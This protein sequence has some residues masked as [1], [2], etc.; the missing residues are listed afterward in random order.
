VQSNHPDPSE[1]GS[2]ANESGVSSED[3]HGYP[4]LEPHYNIA[5]TSLHPILTL[6]PV[7]YIADDL[8]LSPKKV[9][10]LTI[11]CPA[12]SFRPKRLDAK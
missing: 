4:I 10:T 1:S 5:P 6:N 8:G 9:D 12:E 7:G 3:Y 11:N 2:V